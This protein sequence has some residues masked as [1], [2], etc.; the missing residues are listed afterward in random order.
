[1]SSRIEESNAPQFQIQTK[2]ACYKKASA[3]AEA[4]NIYKKAITL[5]C[6]AGRLTNAAKLSKEI[7]EI[8]ESE[9]QPVEAIECYE[10][11]G[12]LYSM[13]DSKSHASSCSAKVAE[14]S[15]AALDPPDL[16][17]AA[18][19]YEELGK[20]CLDSSLLKY[21]AKGYFLQCVLC[22][23]ANGDAIAAMQCQ[24]RAT[25]MDYG[26]GD[27]REGKFCAGLIE[28][29]EQFDADGFATVCFEYDR[30]SKLDAWKTSL[31][32]K[33]KMTIEDQAGGGGEDDDVDLT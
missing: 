12:E 9:G 23:L 15:S 6:D 24:Q 20:N 28:C 22:H 5:L 10:Q 26:Y 4:V 17:K 31:L 13:E 19:L 21:N 25:S 18:G 7:A 1:M 29:V 16:L 11:A 3:T 14:L 2:G 8:F 33:V 32:Y 27:S 30:V